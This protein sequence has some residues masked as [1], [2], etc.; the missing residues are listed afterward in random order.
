MLDKYLD[1]GEAADFL[2]STV[3]TLANWRAAGS[4]PRFYRMG[5][6]I[7]Y[8]KSDLQAWWDSHCFRSI[9]EYGQHKAPLP[10][11]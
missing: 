3:K 11:E 10:A 1:V 2:R 7:F 6:R 9:S 4:G 5:S 8:R